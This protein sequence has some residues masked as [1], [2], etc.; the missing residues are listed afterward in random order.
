M[1]TQ[2]IATR[3]D[4]SGVFVCFSVG[5]INTVAKQQLGEEGVCFILT[6]CSLSSREDRAGTQGRNLD[7]EPEVEPKLEE[8]C[9]LSGL[10]SK[11]TCLGKVLPI[12]DWT[13]LHQ[14][15]IEKTLPRC[16]HRLI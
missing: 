13:F 15:A 8:Y 4:E 3:K 6:L 14:P 9:S 5:V 16:A 11:L 1:T 12:A 10:A 2:G 7:A